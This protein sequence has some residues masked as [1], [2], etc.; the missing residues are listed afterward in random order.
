VAATLSIGDFAKATQLS[1][2]TLRH[3]HE[4]GLLVPASVAP[5]SGY[6]RYSTDQIPLAQVIRRFRALDMPLCTI[7]A[8]LNADD[9]ATRSEMIAQHL[10]T[11]E[12]Q[13][14]RTQGAVESLRDLLEGPLVA[15]AIEHRSEAEIAA[16]AIT[17]T[18]DGA[19]LSDWFQG[20]VGELRAVLAAQD[21]PPDGPSGAVVS[22]AFFADERGALT[23]FVP[24][25]APVR[26]VGRVVPH[27]LPAVELAVV[28]HTG[29][30]S[31]IDR[32]YGALAEHVA[33]RAIAVDGPI[34]ERYLVGPYETPNETQWRTEIGWPIFR[35]DR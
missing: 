33:E 26:P 8:V 21:L 29:S 5:G 32:T 15:R 2:K 6:R 16:A 27:T 1:V 4:V 9:P 7:D 12:Q 18:I 13:L 24:T 17:A 22:D 34:R 10:A 3:Y 35:T 23:V 11:L 31:T 30:H 19:D 25:P 20:A 14:A 28:V